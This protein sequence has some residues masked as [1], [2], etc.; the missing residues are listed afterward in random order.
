M[1]RVYDDI[2]SATEC[3]TPVLAAFLD[4]SSAFDTISHDLL[5]EKLH[6]MY[7][8]EGP[9][10]NWIKTYLKERTV[11]VKID[12]KFSKGRVTTS[13]VPQGSVLGPLLFCLYIQEIHEIVR[14]HNI[15]YHIFADD[16]Q[17][18]TPL[19]T[20]HSELQSLRLCVADIKKWAEAN[21]LKFND[22]KTKYLQINAPNRRQIIT[23]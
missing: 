10:L 8:I 12:D 17:L 5:I 1:L 15:S 6:L 21:S 22:N 11:Y 13:G 18:Y 3:D 19:S 14:K 4:F 20:N 9:A 2:L 23:L 16:V 7:G